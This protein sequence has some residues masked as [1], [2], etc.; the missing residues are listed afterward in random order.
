MS[1]YIGYFCAPTMTSRIAIF[2]LLLLPAFLSGQSKK[3][4]G[5]D[6]RQYRHEFTGGFGISN[7][8]GELGGSDGV[9]K[10]FSPRDLELSQTKL[11]YS[12][13]YRYNF[14]KRWSGRAQYTLCKVSGSDQL[15]NNP[16]RKYRNLAFSSN[17]NEIGLYAEYHIKRADWGHSFYVKGV[18]GSAGQRISLLA[19]TGF[20]WFKFRPRYNGVDLQP[21]KTEGQGMP[22]GPKA[23]KTNA[24]ALPVG[25]LGSY[26]LHK[27]F[28]VGLDINFRF[29]NTDYLDDVSGNYYDREAIR[30]GVSDLAAEMSD[31]SDRTQPS[32]TAEGAPRGNPKSTDFYFT[33]MA[34]VTYTPFVHNPRPPKRRMA[35]K[36]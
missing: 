35:P 17:I 29:T 14:S 18:I 4:G 34:V 1:G 30:K 3:R 19:Y 27:Y 6:F 21:L 26:Q 9:P 7:Y 28:Q 12:L 5:K 24:I 36:F 22:D 11:A 32:W 10:R 13:G 31:R 25:L 20:S 23:Y 8:L 33:V 16:E 15:T 2:T